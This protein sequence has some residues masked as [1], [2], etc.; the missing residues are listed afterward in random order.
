MPGRAPGSGS[1]RN[2]ADIEGGAFACLVLFV[3]EE[4]GLVIYR[5]NVTPI[6]MLD[7]AKWNLSIEVRSETVEGFEG[8]LSFI[9]ARDGLKYDSPA[10]VQ[11]QRV[12][13]RSSAA[14]TR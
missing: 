10:F 7:Y 3:Q 1:W 14:V 13:P 11:K 12:P 6:G 4:A 2:T 8:V 5:D 9:I